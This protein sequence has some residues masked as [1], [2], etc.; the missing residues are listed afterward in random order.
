[1]GNPAEPK[2]QRL[3]RRQPPLYVV[4]GVRHLARFLNGR[5]LVPALW[6]A[7]FTFVVGMVL[8]LGLESVIKT[9][10]NTALSFVVLFVVIF[11]G[12]I[13]DIIGT[14]ATAANITPFNAMAARKVPG[15]REAVRV[16]CNA[17]L[18]ANLAND[19]AGDIAG[20][21]SGAIGASIVF[22][23]SYKFSIQ[24]TVLLGAAM[25]SLI[26]A[27]TVGGKKMGKSVAIN[28]ANTIV[29]RVARVIR[30]WDNLTG[31]SLLSGRR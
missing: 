2:S 21:L 19:V 18:V 12:I 17:D 5:L 26:A 15:A 1:M 10:Q 11:L 13:T 4:Y 23:I 22:S 7:F 25:T 20:T 27:V 24:N 9:V 8:S 30:W 3:L 16:V 14:A 31:M 6:V 28:N 29:L